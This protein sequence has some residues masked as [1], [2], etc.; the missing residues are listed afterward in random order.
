VLNFRRAEKQT[1]KNELTAITT[2]RMAVKSS[3]LSS[4]CLHAFGTAL[5]LGVMMLLSACNSNSRTTPAVSLVFISV[6]SPD[7]A[8][9]GRVEAGSILERDLEFFEPSGS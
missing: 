5:L 1:R 3:G 2:R 7:G 8:M 9:A 4:L 6:G